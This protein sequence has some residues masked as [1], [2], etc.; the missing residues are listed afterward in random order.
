MKNAL[1]TTYCTWTSYGSVLQAY[2]LQQFLK[3]MGVD[4]YIVSDSHDPE[5]DEKK[6]KYGGLK[7]IVKNF[8]DTVQ[9]SKIHRR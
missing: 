2:A 9:R 3:T 1:V 8:L 6:K 5:Y 4:S 7:N